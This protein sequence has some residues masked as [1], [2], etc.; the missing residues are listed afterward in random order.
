MENWLKVFISWFVVTFLIIYVAWRFIRRKKLRNSIVIKIF[1]EIE[2]SGL[3]KENKLTLTLLLLGTLVALIYGLYPSTYKFLL[4]FEILDRPIIKYTGLLILKLSLML[5]IIVN[6]QCDLN[7]LNKLQKNDFEPFA[8]R[9]N[10][11]L[12]ASVTFMLI[13]LFMT[14]PNIGTLLI[15]LL[16]FIHAKIVLMKE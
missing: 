9:V 10:K 16:A 13:G 6:I 1:P 4:R 15:A 3:F 5:L 7:I 14:L 11:M 8:A 2:I 12:T